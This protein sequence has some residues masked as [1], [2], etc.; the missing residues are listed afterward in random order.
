MELSSAVSG[1][2][3]LLAKI[4]LMRLDRL[5]STYLQTR[6]VEWDL[7]DASLQRLTE[8]LQEGALDTR[9]ADFAQQLK[10]VA[11]AIVTQLPDL[12]SQVA[13]S[14]CS[15]LTTLATHLGDHGG[16]DRPMRERCYR[17]YLPWQATATRCS[18]LLRET[19]CLSCWYPVTLKACL[20][21]VGCVDVAGLGIGQG[22]GQGQG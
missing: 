19:V 21:C 16:L 13:K 6:D 12:R 14:A 1:D 7:R 18:R 4:R 11:T 8:L 10:S 17:H 22:Q 3:E 2:E 15:S 5:V 9:S 20:R